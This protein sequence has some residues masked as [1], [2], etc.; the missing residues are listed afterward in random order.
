MTSRNKIDEVNFGETVIHNNNPQT[1][2]FPSSFK[3]NNEQKTRWL[4]T[5][6]KMMMVKNVKKIIQHKQ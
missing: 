1:S 2:F 5:G 4:D 6:W 3:H